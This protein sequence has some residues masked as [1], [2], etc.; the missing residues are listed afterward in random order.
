MRYREK[1]NIV[2]MRDN[3]PR[4]SIQI[5]RSNFFLLLIAFGCLPFLCALLTTQ[6]WLLWQENVRLRDGLE[7]AETDLQVVAAKAERLEN[8]EELLK[9]ENAAGRAIVVAQLAGDSVAALEPAQ[10]Q[11][12]PDEA[13]PGHEEFPVLDT[14]RVKVGNVQ[15]RSLRGSNLRIGLDL[16]NPDNEPLLSGEVEATLLT[17]DGKRLPLT[18]SSSESAAFRISRFKRAVVNA[19]APDGDSLVNAQLILEVKDQD[20]KTIYRNVFSVLQ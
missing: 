3:G 18:F 19:R 9:E 12:A 14:G 2:F 17:A 8:L 20:K 1:L 5:R 11:A 10:T 13:G 16:R 15:V 4:R 6:C 7:R